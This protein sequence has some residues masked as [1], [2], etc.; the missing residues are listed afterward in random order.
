MPRGHKRADPDAIVDAETAILPGR[1]ARKGMAN[2][3]WMIRIDMDR[4]DMIIYVYIYT[5]YT[6]I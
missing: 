4:Y 5:L 3:K 2:H 6:H 1:T